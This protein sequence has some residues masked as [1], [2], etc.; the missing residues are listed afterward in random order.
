M[1]WKM[2]L[3]GLKVSPSRTNFIVVEIKRHFSILKEVFHT[4][5]THIAALKSFKKKPNQV[6][7]ESL[8]IR[9]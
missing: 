9:N 8:K 1:T 2:N 3:N 6:G 5:L 4:E 7:F